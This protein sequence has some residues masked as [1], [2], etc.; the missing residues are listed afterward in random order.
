MRQRGKCK[1]KR[2]LCNLQL[3]ALHISF[4]A[5]SSAAREEDEFDT[6]PNLRDLKTK[7]APFAMQEL[8]GALLAAISLTDINFDDSIVPSNTIADDKSVD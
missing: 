3:Y 5:Y 2:N 7:L 8:K 1:C 4:S 6:T